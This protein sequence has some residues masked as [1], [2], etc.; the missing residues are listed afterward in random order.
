MGDVT[1]GEPGQHIGELP[2]YGGVSGLRWRSVE[3]WRA[4]IQGRSEVRGRC[5]GSRR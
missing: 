4:G 3:G 2:R 5:V 1:V